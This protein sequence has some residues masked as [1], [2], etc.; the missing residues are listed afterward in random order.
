M[1][2]LPA[3]QVVAE[4]APQGACPKCDRLPGASGPLDC[5]DAPGCNL[6]IPGALDPPLQAGMRRRSRRP[7]CGPPDLGATPERPTSTADEKNSSAAP[8]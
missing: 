8:D 5:P 7:G 6:E 2:K 1:P 4:Y 3:D